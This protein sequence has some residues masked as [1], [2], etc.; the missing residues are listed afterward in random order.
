VVDNGST[1]ESVA[2]LRKHFDQIKIVEL[3]ENKGFGQAINIGADKAKGTVLAFVNN[4]MEFPLEWLTEAISALHSE[5]KVGAVQCRIMSYHSRQ[6][7]DSVG[8]SVD[9]YNLPLAIGHDQIDK[10]QYDSLELI[11]ACSGGAMIIPRSIF[12]EAG[13]FDPVY[14]MY[15]EDIDLNWRLKFAG[16]K[17]KSS[18]SSKVYHVGSASSDVTLRGIF[19]PSKF[20]AFETTKNYLYCWLKNSG[21]MTIIIYWP[22]ILFVVISLSV[23]SLLGRKPRT[24]LAYYK[25]IVWILK[26]IKLIRERRN[27]IK[28]VRRN[29]SDNLLFVEEVSQSSTNLPSRFRR[30]FLLGRAMIASRV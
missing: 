8:L 14:F 5:D 13:C 11:G 18:K 20:F 9:R 16:Y 15:Y 19:S 4:D 22:I 24:F 29:S 7:I 12:F 1:D 17:V 23:F 10:G 27:E 25:G 26:N 28:A 3:N 30:A 6:I 2:F 21:N